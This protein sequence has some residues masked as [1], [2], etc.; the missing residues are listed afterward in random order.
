MRGKDRARAA[1][2]GRR[3]VRDLDDRA[4]RTVAAESG[5]RVVGHRGVR[6]GLRVRLLRGAQVLADPGRI[7]LGDDVVVC[8]W[9]VV[10]SVGG[11]IRI[12]ARSSVGDGSSLYGQGDLTVGHDVLMGSGV[13]LLTATHEL[14]DRD[15][16]INRQGESVA[17]TVIGDD[18]WIG[19]N[20]V[21]LAGV[22]VGS[23]AVLAAGAVV[24]R[25]VEPFDIVG[26]V[27]A[28]PIGHR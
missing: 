24:T 2:R 22:T 14:T 17:P 20:V 3:L 18:V 13:R 12:G 16:P 5:A 8:R 1:L 25:D 26:G 9:A 11:S 10:Q 6:A 15:R 27:P 21:V 28:A 4:W 23:G 7:D 19:T